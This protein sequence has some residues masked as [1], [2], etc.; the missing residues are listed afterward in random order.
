MH[1]KRK[2]N[3]LFYNYRSICCI[4]NK[5]LQV[6]YYFLYFLIKDGY[7]YKKTNNIDFLSIKKKK[8]GLIFERI[9]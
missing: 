2:W 8:H 5:Q 3:I 7:T 9:R 4:V 6:F 1:V